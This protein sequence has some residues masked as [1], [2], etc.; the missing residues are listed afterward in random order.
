MSAPTKAVSEF[1]AAVDRLLQV[2]EEERKLMVE[3][4]LVR[5]VLTKE[6][7]V[8]FESFMARVNQLNAAAEQSAER[9]N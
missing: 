5:V 9:L 3:W 2:S 6:E 8:L 4:G 1:Q 7:A